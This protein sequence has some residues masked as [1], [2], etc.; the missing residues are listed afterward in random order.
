MSAEIIAV[1]QDCFL[2]G[3]TSEKDQKML[4]TIAKKGAT[5]R[6]LSFATME[7]QELCAKA[8]EK[9]VCR[10]PF[11]TDGVNFSQNYEDILGAKT[12]KEVKVEAKPI[13]AKRSKE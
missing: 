7:G 2:C 5:F 12:V 6:K 13:K 11:F 8:I 1:Y 10:F 9:G 3:S 4:E